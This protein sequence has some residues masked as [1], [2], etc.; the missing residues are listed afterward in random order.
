MNNKKKT[1]QDSSLTDKVSLEK[2]RK[3]KARNKE[4][5]SRLAG[6]QLL[7]GR[8]SESSSR[9]GSS[10]SSDFQVVEDRIKI[11]WG[12]LQCFGAICT[13]FD[14]IPWPKRFQTFSVSMGNFFSFDILSLFRFSSCELVI[15][16]LDSVLVHMLL[17]IALIIPLILARLLPYKLKP[18]SRQQQ[19][20]FMMK[21]AITL[22]LI[23]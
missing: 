13:V 21:T 8:L 7:V 5:A 2:Q 15:P 17:P 23:L 1:R 19:H 16:F 22:L 12:W 18:K 20:E 10:T 4:A 9:K 6:D 11:I 3:A 14:S